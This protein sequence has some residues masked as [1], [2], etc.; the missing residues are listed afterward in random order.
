MKLTLLQSRLLALAALFVA[1][2]CSGLADQFTW[3][4]TYAQAWQGFG[5]GPYAAINTATLTRITIFCLDY[6]DEIAPPFTWNANVVALNQQNVQNGAQY[7]GNY[8]NLLNSAYGVTHPGQPAPNQVSGPPFAFQG[9]S[10]GSYSVNLSADNAYTRYQEAAWLFTEIESVNN[11]NSNPIAVI[12]QVAAWELFANSSH[13]NAAHTGDLQQKIA[14]TGGTYTFQDN[15]DPSSSAFQTLTGLTFQQAIDEY[16]LAAQTAVRSGSFTASN[17]S[18]VTADAGWVESS[19]G[20]NGVPAQE[21]L[22]PDAPRDVASTPEP[23]A[24]LLLATAIAL[25]L[26]AK[27]YKLRKARDVFGI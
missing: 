13:V 23:G 8:N 1:G 24:I 26:A 20:G 27:R 5:T 15:V 10:S 2:S 4:N 3:G 22:S 16:L 19:L 14:A 17:W 7:G 6:N 25:T 11:V 12:A 21:F 9:D 18:L